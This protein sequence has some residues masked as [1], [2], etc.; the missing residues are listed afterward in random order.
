MLRVAIKYYMR[1]MIV[2]N[3]VVEV[4]FL[5]FP[6]LFF[7][8]GAFCHGCD[9]DGDS[10]NTSKAGYNKVRYNEVTDMGAAN[11]WS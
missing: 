4:F 8:F 6:S 3:F 10:G 11:F 2:L 1:L 7:F 9:V 5:F